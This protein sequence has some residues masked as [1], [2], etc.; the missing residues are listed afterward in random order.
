MSKQH[1]QTTGEVVLIPCPCCEAEAKYCQWRDTLEPNATWVEC[2]N[3][4]CGLTTD[5]V[6]HKDPEEAKRIVARRW[7]KRTGA[8][9]FVAELR[10]LTER[11]EAIIGDMGQVCPSPVRKAARQTCESCLVELREKLQKFDSKNN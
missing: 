8:Q 4:E 6:H 7:N 2:T 3:E 9:T 1:H 11:W 5:D 10:E